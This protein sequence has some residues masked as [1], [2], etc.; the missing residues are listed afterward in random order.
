MLQRASLTLGLLMAL[1]YPAMADE[2]SRDISKVQEALSTPDR[3]KPMQADM[4]ADAVRQA[5]GIFVEQAQADQVAG[6]EK[7]CLTR[8]A[9]A[10]KILEIE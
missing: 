4:S 10:K 7:T 3:I 8:I 6:N 1:A 9:A 2:C 5:I